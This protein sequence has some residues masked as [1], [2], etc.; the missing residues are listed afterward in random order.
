[1]AQMGNGYGS[2]CHLLRYMGRHRDQLDEVVLRQ[3]KANSIHWLDFHFD[4]QRKWPD[5]EWE[6]LGFLPERTALRSA[7]RTS[8]PPGGTCS[9]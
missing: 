9:G 1:M 5:A 2:E 6:G 4:R 3:I 8:W 7:W